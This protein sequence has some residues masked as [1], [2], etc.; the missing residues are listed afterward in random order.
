MSRRTRLVQ[1]PLR[2]GEAFELPIGLMSIASCLEQAG[3]EV[4]IVTPTRVEDVPKEDM[5][6][7]ISATTPAMT[8][9]G[10]IARYLK[11][12]MMPTIVMGGVH[13][14]LRPYETLCKYG[15]DYVVAGEGEYVA[16][17]L[18]SSILKEEQ[19]AKVYRGF[20]P[21]VDLHEIPFPAY[22]L[23]RDQIQAF[24]RRYRSHFDADYTTVIASRGCPFA[25]AFCAVHV[26][27]RRGWRAMSPG[28]LGELVNGLREQYGITGVFFK[29]STFNIN[30]QWLLKVCEALSSLGVE[31][32][33]NLRADLIDEDSLDAM[34]RSGCRRVIYGVESGD[35]EILHELKGLK[36]D[37]FR[38]AFSKTRSRGIE[39][40]ANWLIGT[41]WESRET[42]QR[43][44]H[45]MRELKATYDDVFAYSPLPGSSLYDYCLSSGLWKEP[46]DWGVLDY[47]YFN[48]PT[49]HLTMEE[50]TDLYRE[51]LKVGVE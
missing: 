22:H 39:I 11:H 2:E 9:T 14:T 8:K 23:V 5:I 18:W 48:M 31:W 19:R 47:R 15:A 30:K 10:Q 7:G 40:E 50:L 1:P 27:M 28:R 6:Y 45:F 42:V 43:T 26:T 37:D 33:C 32:I 16:P 34:K 3:W 36:L 4:E 51:L 13:P 21:Q 24:I 12:N 41:P 46:A 44:K 38:R 29:D 20:V 35:P 17:K 49:H 25:C